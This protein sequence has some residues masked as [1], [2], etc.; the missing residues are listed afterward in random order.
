MPKL[1]PEQQLVIYRVTQ[2]GLSNV[3]QHAG[4]RKVDVELSFVGRT[5]LRI[6][7]NG[8]GFSQLNGA[9]RN[10]GLGVLGMRERAL[11][12]GG[13]RAGEFAVYSHPSAG[14]KETRRTTTKG[15]DDGP[16]FSSDGRTI[17][18][19]SDRSGTM[20][21]WRI[22][23]DGS[24]PEQLTSDEFN[25]WFPHVS[26]DGR[27]IASASQDGFLELWDTETWKPLHS[28]RAEDGLQSLAFSPIGRAFLA[29]PR[30]G[31]FMSIEGGR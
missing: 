14:G 20:Q 12:C 24:D 31:F 30:G 28:F 11:V 19:N 3:A 10:G 23:P 16:E 22:K 25:N 7:D 5:V 13:E 2:E 27:R 26:P 8:R 21:I 1:T 29:D 17:Y 18:F 4:A 9:T 15:L 6:S